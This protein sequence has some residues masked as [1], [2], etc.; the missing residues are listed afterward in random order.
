MDP[1]ERAAERERV[2]YQ[3]LGFRVHLGVY[4]AVNALLFA[5]WALT[6][7]WTDDG[8]SFPWFLFPLLGWG[9]GLVAHFAVYSVVSRDFKERQLRRREAEAEEQRRDI[10]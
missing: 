8:I 9:V 6:S 5:T 2:D 3:K 1:F 4:L 7:G 10:S